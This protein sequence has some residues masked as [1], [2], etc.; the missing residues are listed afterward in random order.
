M[1]ADGEG[2]QLADNIAYPLQALLGSTHQ[3][4]R[5]VTHKVQINRSAHLH[6]CLCQGLIG[7]AVLSGLILIGQTNQLGQILT[8]RGDIGIHHRNRVVDFMGHTRRQMPQRCH[9]LRLQQQ[10]LSALQFI[11]TAL[12][13]M[14]A[15]V[16]GLG[17]GFYLLFELFI[18]LAHAVLG[19]LT[20]ADLTFHGAQH[21]VHFMRQIVQFTVAQR[22]LHHQ[23]CGYR[24]TRVDGHQTFHQTLQRA[25][26]TRAEYQNQHH[27]QRDITQHIQQ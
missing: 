13:L 19:L 6:Q 20:L 27:R 16:Q 14:V 8:Q 26:Q 4:R 10:I 18:Q 21:I 2:A 17:T 24:L 11:Q 25:G 5:V 9:P 3:I 23:R 1:F 7:N 12:Q 22:A 15:V